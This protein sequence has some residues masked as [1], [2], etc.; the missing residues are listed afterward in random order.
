VEI[1]YLRA[2]C[3]SADWKSAIRQSKTL[4]Y[5]R[6]ANAPRFCRINAAFRL[7]SVAFKAWIRASSRRLLQGQKNL[8][9]WGGTGDGGEFAG[10]FGASKVADLIKRQNSFLVT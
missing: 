3:R 9:V 1:S 8:S 2:V 6:Q 4:R 7:A 5:W 10:G